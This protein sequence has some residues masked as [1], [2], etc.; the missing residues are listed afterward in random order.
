MRISDVK[1]K[2]NSLKWKNGLKLYDRKAFL[3][4]IKVWGGE[5]EHST[6]LDLDQLGTLLSILFLVTD[7]Y[8][9]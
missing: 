7:F 9:C 2:M 3:I 8:W 4:S 6:G 5:E 1:R